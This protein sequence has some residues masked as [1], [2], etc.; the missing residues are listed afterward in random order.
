MNAHRLLTELTRPALSWDSSSSPASGRTAASGDKGRVT[1]PKKTKETVIAISGSLAVIRLSYPTPGDAPLRIEPSAALKQQTI[2]RPVSSLFMVHRPRDVLSRVER[3]SLS[4]FTVE[5][6]LVIVPVYKRSSTVVVNRTDN[7]QKAKHL[8]EDGLFYVPCEFNLIKTLTREI[9]AKLLAMENSGAT[10]P[11]DRRTAKLQETAL[12]QF[13]GRSSPAQ[14]HS[15][16]QICK[17]AI[18]ISH[19]SDR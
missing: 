16:L 8:L 7:L 11:M 18:S 2:V 12:T 10:V 17:V 14:R 13:V 15:N 1:M 6:D 3:D 9:N 5:N 4:E 19:L